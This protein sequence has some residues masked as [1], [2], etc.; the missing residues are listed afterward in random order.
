MKKLIMNLVF[1]FCWK[2]FMNSKVDSLSEEFW[3]LACVRLQ[4][5]GYGHK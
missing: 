1:R 2:M 4:M 3:N 5:K